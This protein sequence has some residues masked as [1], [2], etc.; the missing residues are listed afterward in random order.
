[1]LDLI[2]QRIPLAVRK[3]EGNDIFQCMRK[4]DGDAARRR[5]GEEEKQTP[6]ESFAVRLAYGAE[7]GAPRVE[8][9]DGITGIY[10]IFEPDRACLTRG[11]KCRVSRRGRGRQRTRRTYRCHRSLLSAAAQ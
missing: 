8:G 3:I 7:I 4:L 11:A 2:Y 9:L 1:M 5:T 6:S 10:A